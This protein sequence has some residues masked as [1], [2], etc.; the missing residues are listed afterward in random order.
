MEPTP[1]QGASREASGEDS[2]PPSPAKTAKRRRHSSIQPGPDSDE[3]ENE[4][5]QTVTAGRTNISTSTKAPTPPPSSATSDTDVEL[6][7][8]PARIG[9][10]VWGHRSINSC[11]VDSVLTML[12]INSLRSKYSFFSNFKSKKS[13]GADIENKLRITLSNLNITPGQP[14]NRQQQLQNSQSLH[15]YWSHF[16]GLTDPVPDFIGSA[17]TKILEHLE[18]IS[19]ISFYLE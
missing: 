17:S 10:L 3:S 7:L 9:G 19:L 18:P 16:T 15:F 11:T 6:P 13:V 12:K 8:A 1:N 4:A 2:K 14:E 5:L